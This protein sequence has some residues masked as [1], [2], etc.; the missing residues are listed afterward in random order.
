MH[1]TILSYYPTN[2]YSTILSETKYKTT[3]RELITILTTKQM[4]Q[5]LA[6]ALAQA[7]AGDTCKDLLNK[8]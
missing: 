1:Y 5:R 2:N 7:K 6:T 3:D 4:F 8:I